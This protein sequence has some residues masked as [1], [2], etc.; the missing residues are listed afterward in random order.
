MKKFLFHIDLRRLILWMCFFFVALAL[1]NSFYAAYQ[2]QRQ[3]LVENTLEANRVYAQKL[4]HITD[5]YIRSSRFLLEGAAADL[6]RAPL[7]QQRTQDKL[8]QVADMTTSFNSL[9]IAATSGVVIAGI[10]TNLDVIGTAIEAPQI[11]QIL[12]MCRPYITAPFQR[13]DDAWIMMITQPILDR[14]DQCL[15][16]IAGTIYLHESNALRSALGDHFYKDGSYLYVVDQTGTVIYHPLLKQVGTSKLDNWSVQ[17][18]LRGERGAVRMQAEDEIDMLAG[19]APV[20]S[21]GW[22][23]VA[24]RPTEAAL[25]DLGVL[26]RR[27]FYYSV[28][29]LLL[30][31]LAISWLSKL[32]A[33]PL[34]DLAEVA[35]NLDNRANF[36][37]IR[38]I[39]GWYHEA[40]LLREALLTGFSAVALRLRRL[41]QENS[42]DPLTAVTNRRGLDAVLTVLSQDKTPVAIVLLDIDNFKLVND[43]Y[44]HSVGDEVLKTIASVAVE[45]VRETDIVA[46]LGGEEFVVVLPNTTPESALLFAERLRFSIEHTHFGPCGT[47]TISLGVAQYPAHASSVDGALK[48]ADRALYQA[49]RDGR[50]CTRQAPDL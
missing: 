16:Y 24:Q 15:G 11:N 3:V 20:A 47:I 21:T 19:Y 12:R 49:K 43:T 27:T 28:P 9:F 13:G 22:G 10:P 41:H 30:S 29:I 5:A 18:A 38:Y 42:T 48:L 46:R 6:G 4:A 1:A 37:R 7:T 44:G 45:Q 17:A 8:A 23:I 26:F 50:N 35:S 31:L 32:I 2:V 25:S 39:K 40:A 14:N 34:T 33:R 36:A